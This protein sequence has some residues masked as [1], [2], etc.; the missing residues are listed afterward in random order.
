[1]VWHGDDYTD[2][3]FDIY[4]QRID[5]TTGSEVGPDDFRISQTRFPFVFEDLDASIPDVTYNA[6]ADEYLVVWTAD[7]AGRDNELEIFGQMI[8]GSSGSEVGKDDFR[9]SDM[10]PDRDTRFVASFSALAYS[11]GSDEYLVVWEGD[12]SVDGEFE[13]YGQRI[14]GSAAEPMGEFSPSISVTLDDQSSGPLA[15]MSSLQLVRESTVF[16]DQDDIPGKRILQ[17][18][19]GT[20]NWDSLSFGS[21]PIETEG[22]LQV[23]LA[24]NTITAAT[25]KILYVVNEVSENSANL[26]AVFSEIVASPIVLALVPEQFGNIAQEAIGFRAIDA[27]LTRSP[28]GAGF[29]LVEVFNSGK[30]VSEDYKGFSS[31]VTIR[32]TFDEDFFMT[33]R[34]GGSLQMASS[35]TSRVEKLS[36]GVHVS[37]FQITGPP[38]PTIDLDPNPIQVCEGRVGQTSI[39]WDAS[40][41]EAVEVRA[42]A[43][44]G[45]VFAAGLEQGTKQT[46]NWVQDG[47]TF[48]LVDGASGEVLGSVAATFTDEGCPLS[49]RLYFPQFGNGQGLFSE[50]VLTSLALGIQTKVT[51]NLRDDNGNPLTVNLNGQ[52]VT[53]ELSVILPP[54][55]VLRF[56]SDGIGPLISGSVTVGAENDVDGVI[57]FGGDTG[58]AGVGA[59]PGFEHGFVTQPPS[60]QYA[61][62]TFR[63]NTLQSFGC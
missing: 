8:E 28:D 30:R 25:A 57:L 26:R 51:I 43:P 54:G 6:N 27:V 9:I 19:N 55:G 38:A 17:V 23:V 50:I 47:M 33:P 18:D 44:D 5:G 60:L 15:P 20:V 2:Q 14:E 13:I 39:S 45:N 52:Q 62:N 53:G 42:G 16:L 48:Y 46:G 36:S 12:D 22:S 21:T 31:Q 10:G 41:F 32:D 49:P 63:N 24:G 61:H 35:F 37:E 34:F 7:G 58:L 11:E 56:K 29:T 59:S 4:G 1:M 3:E 40:G